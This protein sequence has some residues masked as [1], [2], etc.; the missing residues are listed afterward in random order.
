MSAQSS[1][2]SRAEKQSAAKERVAAMRAQE[3]QRERRQKLLIYGVAGLVVVLIAALVAVQMYRA[4]EQEDQLAED[5]E[6]L[7]VYDITDREH[8]TGTVDY[9][10]TPP[11]GGDH[12]T[13]PEW[14]NCGIYDTAVPNENAVHS[15]E[16]GAVW[17]TY[18]PDL[19]EDQVET[20]RDVVRDL[21]SSERNYVILSPFE[22]IPSPVVA[23][24]WNHQVFMD[25]ASD[26]RLEQF[27]HQYVRGEQTLEPGAACSQ[28]V[29]S[30]IE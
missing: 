8:V 7:E 2:S 26:I 5:I 24:A 3:A 16:H 12:A 11:A 17:I 4:G 10:H 20:L 30:P 25:D 1:K 6:G 29:G 28:G 9:E 23:S 15:L 27:L 13:S 14:L 21:D 19:P 18:Q 22:G